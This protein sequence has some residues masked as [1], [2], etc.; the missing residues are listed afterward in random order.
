MDGK[1]FLIPLLYN[2]E[3]T[4]QCPG[5]PGCH[6]SN[7]RTRC[8]YQYMTRCTLPQQ[9]IFIGYCCPECVRDLLVPTMF[10]QF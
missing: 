6:Q 5:S 2:L 1:Q 3:C 7:V 8:Q 4:I 10:R 9:K